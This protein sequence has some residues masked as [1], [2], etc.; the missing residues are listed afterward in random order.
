MP[1]EFDATAPVDQLQRR[2]QHIFDEQK[3]ENRI[4][5]LEKRL[6]QLEKK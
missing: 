2:M 4:D 1:F 3:L 5:Q 6:D